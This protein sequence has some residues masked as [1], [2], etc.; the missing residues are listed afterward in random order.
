M[1]RI[2]GIA[3]VLLVPCLASAEFL[4]A[5]RVVDPERSFTLQAS[6]GQVRDIKGGVTE[7]TRRLFELEGRDPSTFAPES[8]TFEELGLGDSEPTF[9]IA[10]EKNW[11]YFTLRGDLSYMCAEANAAPPRDFFIGVD[12]IEFQGRSYEYMKLEDGI[13]YEASLDAALI[14]LRLQYT[15]FTLGAEHVISFTPLVHVGFFAIAGTFEVSQGE[16]QRI[17]IY[18][19]PPRE[20][21]VGGKGDGTLGGF[22][23]E[24]GVG[25]EFRIWL[26]RN[27]YG[28]R[29]LA[30]QGTYAIFEYDGSSDAL[31]ISSRN[32]KDLDVDYE[33]LELRAMLYLPISSGS[34]LVIGAEY[35]MMTANAESRSRARTLS[36][37]Q[38][39]RE[40]F[41]KEIDLELSIVNAFVGL[42]F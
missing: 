24:I 17:Q 11:R 20:Y 23:P 2:A 35:K 25:G 10:F 42:R 34:D 14:S 4:A 18:E 36:E 26:G 7:T 9:G 41:D 1:S 37:A 31:G 27:Q 38:E 40:K 22:A 5:G 33:M 12:D 32:E 16:P 29:E 30:L 13:P 3:C 28:D 39:N 15:P 6:V 19:N 8:Y 21:V